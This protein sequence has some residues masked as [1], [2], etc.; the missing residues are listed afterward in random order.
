[1][2]LTIKILKSIN[3]ENLVINVTK[4]LIITTFYIHVLSIL[5]INR[6]LNFLLSLSVFRIEKFLFFTFFQFQYLQNLDQHNYCVSHKCV[7]IDDSEKWG[8]QASVCLC[9]SQD[10]LKKVNRTKSSAIRRCCGSS[11]KYNKNCQTDTLDIVHLEGEHCDSVPHYELLNGSKIK[12]GAK[13]IS[14]DSFDICI[15]P[16]LGKAG[17]TMTLFNCIPPCHGKVPCIR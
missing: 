4:V 5:H 8:I 15:G 7:E 14:V 17:L 13:E 10:E 16:T 12:F 2:T 9:P 11:P 3:N 6:D 1:M